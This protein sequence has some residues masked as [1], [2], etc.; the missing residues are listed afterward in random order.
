MDPYT[1]TTAYCTVDMV[2]SHGID[3]AVSDADIEFAIAMITA[4]IDAFYYLNLEEHLGVEFSNAIDEWQHFVRY[5]N[6]TKVFSGEGHEVLMLRGTRLIELAGVVE[7]GS[8]VSLDYVQTSPRALYKYTNSCTQSYECGVP[9]KWIQGINNILVTGDWG[10]AGIPRNIHL[11]ASRLVV[12]YLEG[13]AGDGIASFAS[14]A[15]SSIDTTS[16]SGTAGTIKSFKL[17][18]LSV[19]FGESATTITKGSSDAIKAAVESGLTLKAKTT[20]DPW[21]DTILGGF[22]YKRW[23]GMRVL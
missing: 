2:R 8:A 10:F 1:D 6:K 16:I 3:A 9:G 7:N 20:G 12:M 21:C 5:N 11:V 15:G 17:D 4:Y 13:K 22:L 14:V 19:S 18:D 23:M